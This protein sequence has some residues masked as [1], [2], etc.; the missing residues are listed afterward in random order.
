MADFCGDPAN[1]EVQKRLLSRQDWISR[2]PAV[3]NGGRVLNIVAPD[4]LGWDQIRDLMA[5]DELAGFVAQDHDTF[6]PKVQA[7]LGE[8]YSYPFWQVYRGSAEH[9]RAACEALLFKLDLPDGWRIDTLTHPNEDQIAKVQE[10]NLATGVAPYP[11]YYSAGSLVGCVTTVLWSD[12][13]LAVGSASVVDKFHPDG[14]LGGTVFKGSTCVLPDYR[15]KSLGKLVNAHNLLGSLEAF[16]WTHVISQVQP[17]NTASHRTIGTCG[18]APL[19][20]CVTVGAL[21]N[22]TVFT[23]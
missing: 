17:S 8:H 10:L 1:I 3:A 4:E 11:A 15:G 22:G 12:T 23:R 19:A 21:P 7:E 18:L 9:V 6:L 16:Q 5:E 20:G 13:G 14:R 2:T